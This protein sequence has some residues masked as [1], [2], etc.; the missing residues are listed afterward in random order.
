MSVLREHRS[1]EGAVALHV[2][3][4]GAQSDPASGDGVGSREWVTS[5]RSLAALDLAPVPGSLSEWRS[6]GDASR[7]VVMRVKRV[8]EASTELRQME[9]RRAN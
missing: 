2:S 9:R 3:T 6:V 7:S 5:A 4:A 8:V 1:S